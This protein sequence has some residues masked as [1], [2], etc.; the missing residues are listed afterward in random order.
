MGSKNE[1]ARFWALD[2]ARAA[3]RPQL[4]R[5]NRRRSIPSV[6][7][8]KRVTSVHRVRVLCGDAQNA[9]RQTSPPATERTPRRISPDLSANRPLALQLPARLVCCVY[10]LRKTQPS[11][12][13]RVVAAGNAWAKVPTGLDLLDAAALP[14]V[15]L[16]GAK[17]ADAVESRAGMSILV[18]GAV[19]GVGRSTVFV[20]KAAGA[21]FWP[22]C[23]RNK[24]RPPVCWAPIAQCALAWRVSN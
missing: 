18:T 20:A 21:I 1:G 2:R 22:A 15:A 24:R 17:L 3:A 19:G 11:F 7:R 4:S 23:G 14:L 13:E 5:E 12:A 16:T 10:R 6:L 9:W 8:G